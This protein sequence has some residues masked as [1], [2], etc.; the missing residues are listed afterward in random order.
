MLCV[1][2]TAFL[3]I[4]TLQHQQL[5]QLLEPRLVGAFASLLHPTRTSPLILQKALQFLGR[6]SQCARPCHM[7]SW[8]AAIFNLV[9][10][11]TFPTSLDSSTSSTSTSSSS[12]LASGSMRRTHGSCRRLSDCGIDPEPSWS[13]TE[14]ALQPL[15]NLSEIPE[16]HVCITKHFILLEDLDSP[17]SPHWLPKYS[18]PPL[19]HILLHRTPS[20][21]RAASL[22]PCLS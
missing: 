16:F 5:E 18:R 22:R 8:N 17:T 15:L 2:K 1:S 12:N 4:R 3:S 13:V 21:R 10:L 11:L 14:S 19:I 9:P 7:M 6:A 20:L